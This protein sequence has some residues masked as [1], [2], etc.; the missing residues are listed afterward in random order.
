L[1]GALFSQNPGFEMG[2]VDMITDRNNIRKLLRFVDGTSSESFQIQVEIVDGKRALFTRM[3]N[4]TTTVI[5]GFRGYG[6][7]FEKACTKS[8][9]GTSGYH[10]IT[11][12]RFGGL[13]CVVRHET[14]GYIDDALGQAAAQKQA[15]TTDSLPQ[16]LETLRLADSALTSTHTST[17]TVKREGKE[18]DCSSILEIKTRAAGKSLDMNETAAQLWISQ[19]PHL[20][21]G[22]YKNGLFNDVQV[23]DM[24]QN[25]RDWE[26]SNQKVLCSLGY[27]LNQII[28]VV[29]GSASQV[30]VVKYDGGMKL[31]V[32]AGEQKKA[33]L[34]GV[35]AKW[36]GGKQGT[37]DNK[38]MTEKGD[39]YKVSKHIDNEHI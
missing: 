9:T 22:Y 4:A 29:K 39:Q 19:T 13:K 16:L 20:A 33:P 36:Q 15:K 18:V 17:I 34:E 11:S 35:H 3:E 37:E 31:E 25:V 38:L 23:R 1:F 5:Q 27:L 6:H 7:N 32:I 30:A 14:D 24:A 10:R 21:V 28:E 2:S 12:F 26:R 8:A